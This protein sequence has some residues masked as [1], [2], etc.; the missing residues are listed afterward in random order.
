[1]RPRFKKD[2]EKSLRFER[3]AEKT[4][5]QKFKVRD[6]RNAGVP[7]VDPGRQQQIDALAREAKSGNKEARREVRQLERQQRNDQRQQ[8]RQV[9]QQQRAQPKMERPSSPRAEGT[10]IGNPVKGKAVGRPEF[11]GPPVR[12][13]RQPQ[14]KQNQ[15]GRGEAKQQN[16][17]P[18]QPKGGGGGKGKGK[19]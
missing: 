2:L 7:Q 16:K 12:M 6:E 9:Q 17:T 14:V 18:G 19:P 15:P 8:V 11:K 4:K 13:N 10:R 5:N 1:M 3:I